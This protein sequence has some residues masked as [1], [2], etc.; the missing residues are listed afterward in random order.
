M[1]PTLKTRLSKRVCRNTTHDQGQIYAKKEPI[2]LALFQLF[3]I[4]QLIIRKFGFLLVVLFFLYTFDNQPYKAEAFQD[5][6]LFMSTDESCSQNF[7]DVIST[8]LTK[9]PISL[10]RQYGPRRKRESKMQP[11]HYISIC[12]ILPFVAASTF[13]KTYFANA[14]GRWAQFNVCL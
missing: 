1:Q 9:L 10:F 14:L 6:R 13:K 5:L 11:S 8:L 3:Y 2:K 4:K 12:A 7:A